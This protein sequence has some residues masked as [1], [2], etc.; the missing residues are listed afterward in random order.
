M[1]R[2]R[3]EEAR[4][5]PDTTLSLAPGVMVRVDTRETPPGNVYWTMSHVCL[6]FTPADEAYAPAKWGGTVGSEM[7]SEDE[8]RFDRKDGGLRSLY[9]TV[10]VD[11]VRWAKV[12]GY[13][14]IP[15]ERSGLL[16]LVKRKDFAGPNTVVGAFDPLGS[17]LVGLYVR[18]RAVVPNRT[19]HVA[20]GL[21]LLCDRVAVVGWILHRPAEVLVEDG[22]V[23]GFGN[24]REAVDASPGRS[25]GFLRCCRRPGSTRRVGPM[26]SCGA[27]SMRWRM[28]CV[29]WPRGARGRC[30][31]RIFGVM[32]GN[33]GGCARRC[34]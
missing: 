26:R 1:T 18:A 14:K 2:R 8:Y 15:V 24:G 27:T 9:L 30:C 16:V 7:L 17:A 6:G 34:S 12:S 19:I 32:S 29:G 11:M 22:R 21:D 25:T 23:K 3:R 31:S 13:V 10:P 33:S 5:D 4:L 20:E 28:R